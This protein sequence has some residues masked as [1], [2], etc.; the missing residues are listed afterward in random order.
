M[1]MIVHY[2]DDR[3]VM[4]ELNDI[5]TVPDEFQPWLPTLEPS[6]FA[7][8]QKSIHVDPKTGQLT[9]FFR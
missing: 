9:V 1:V 4:R 2:H 6:P 7:P 3:L 5:L 8:M